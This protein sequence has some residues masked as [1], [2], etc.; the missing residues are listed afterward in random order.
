MEIAHC[1]ADGYFGGQARGHGRSNGTL[2][3][4]IE[5]KDMVPLFLDSS[6]QP[7]F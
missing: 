4:W 2:K 5:P 6:F 7:R 3:K 1:R